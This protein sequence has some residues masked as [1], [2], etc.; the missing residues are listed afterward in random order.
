[1]QKLE[2]LEFSNHWLAAWTGNKPEVLIQFYSDHTFYR[3]PAKPN[4]IS[5][6]DKLFNYFTKLLAKYPDWIWKPIE[7]FPIES[8]FILKWEA[9]LNSTKSTDA[10]FGIDIVEIQDK[11]IIRNEVFFDPIS[12]INKSRK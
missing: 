8:G 7:I 5:G 3:D 6:K 11:K 9:K 12:L 1:M 10:I 2:A 4:G